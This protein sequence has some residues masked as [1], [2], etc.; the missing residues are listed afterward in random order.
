MPQLDIMTYFTQ[1]FW[2]SLGF[3]SFYIFMLHFIMPSIAL[4]LKFRKRKLEV[5]ANDINKKK[6]SA[7]ELLSTYD[8]ILFK[9][10]NTSR[11]YIGKVANYG[12]LWVSTSISKTNLSNFS[13]ANNTYIKT[14]GEK[15]FTFTV[16]DVSLKDSSKDKNW[17]KL[18][19]K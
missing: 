1:F 11:L 16:L 6:E 18:W 14:F 10:L 7:S 2:F 5:L 8:N 17:T 4:S 15:N 3:S 19:K 9:M 13:Q 12:N